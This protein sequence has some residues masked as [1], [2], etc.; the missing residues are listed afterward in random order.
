MTQTP[1]VAA[2]RPRDVGG[3]GSCAAA[4]SPS[5][6]TSSTATSRPGS[7]TPAATPSTSPSMRGATARR[8]PTSARSAPTGPGTSSWQPSRRR[9]STP[10]LTRRVDGPNA[11]ADVRIVDGNRVF[12][13][14]DVGV[15]RFTV[16]AGTTWRP[17]RRS[18]SCTRASAPCSRSSCQ[19]LAEAATH[20]SFDFS[21]R[22]WDYV[23][24][25]APDVSRRHLVPARR[26]PGRRRR[27]GR[28]AL[29]DLGPSL[30]A[31]TLGAGGAVLL[32]E[33]ELAYSP[34]GPGPGRG[35]PRGRR[36]LHRPAPGR[37]RAAREPLQQLVRARHRLRHGE[38][39]LVRRLRAPHTA[40]RP[41]RPSS[42]P[43]AT[44][45]W[46]SDEPCNT[47]EHLSGGG[48]RG[49]DLRRLRRAVQ[50]AR[51]ARPSR[52]T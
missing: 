52:P 5:A 35:H 8:R 13:G 41:R 12:G 47:H 37:P 49:A 34:V 14:A 26:R 22:P 45:D 10:T 16:C 21:E 42:T 31:I 9:A 25:H 27:T 1:T 33:D 15:S 50:R 51:R 19:D 20:L 36:R 11:Y 4:C 23:Q 30:V 3:A 38:L 6:T 39:R 18:T 32:R 24:T 43:S 29:R 28:A 46:T 48:P 17:P 7:C 2:T 40:H 44:A